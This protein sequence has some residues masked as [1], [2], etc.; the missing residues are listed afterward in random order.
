MFLNPGGLAKLTSTY[1]VV[2]LLVTLLV[3]GLTY[4]YKIH[5]GV[6]DVSSTPKPEV[7]GEAVPPT[8]VPMVSGGVSEVDWSKLRRVLWEHP[9]AHQLKLDLALEERLPPD[10][11][12]YT[13][14]YKV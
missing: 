12:R 2:G 8:P 5:R 13:R 9:L 11:I 1:V 4:I 7:G 10:C 3:L 6:V 14:L